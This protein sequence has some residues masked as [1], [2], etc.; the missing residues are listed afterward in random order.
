MPEEL[1]G[2]EV[3]WLTQLLLGG[4]RM[5]C[6]EKHVTQFSAIV[7]L[8]MIMFRTQ[9]VAQMALVR[10]HDRWCPSKVSNWNH[11]QQVQSASSQPLR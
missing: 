8:Q 3:T 11:T 2:N 4:D 9:E 10:E 5:P 6:G 1:A 7:F